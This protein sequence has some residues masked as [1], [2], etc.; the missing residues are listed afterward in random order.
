MRPSRA[1]AELSARAAGG[2]ACDCDGCIQTVRAA[3]RSASMRFVAVRMALSNRH[4]SEASLHP[5]SGAR[6][7]LI[8]PT[9]T[10]A[11]VGVGNLELAWIASREGSTRRAALRSCAELS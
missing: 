5:R 11:G 7:A 3:G 6:G 8:Q 1:I 9:H 10:C 2:N 4:D